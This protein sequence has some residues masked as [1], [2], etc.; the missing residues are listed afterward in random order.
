MAHTTG[1]KYASHILRSLKE[2]ER[3]KECKGVKGYGEVKGVRRLKE[4]GG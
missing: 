4:L 3:L 1:L 2:F